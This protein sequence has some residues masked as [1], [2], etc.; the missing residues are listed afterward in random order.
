M[1]ENSIRE[2]V[3]KMK[4]IHCIIKHRKTAVL[5]QLYL[6]GTRFYNLCYHVKS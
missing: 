4:P 2:F 1:S 3:R 5:V 6:E